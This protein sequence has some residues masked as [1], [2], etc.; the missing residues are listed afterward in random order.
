MAAALTMGCEHPRAPE[1]HF[2]DPYKLNFNFLKRIITM[3]VREQ[4]DDL[5]ILRNL[6]KNIYLPTHST[7]PETG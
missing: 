2:H 4:R 5:V 7:C 1:V 3:I 6:Y